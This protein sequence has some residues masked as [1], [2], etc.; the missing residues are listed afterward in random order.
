MTFPI[1]GLASV[2]VLSYNRPA[3]VREAIS[4][5]KVNAGYPCEIVVHDDGSKDPAVY[6]LLVGLVNTEQISRLILNPT[7]HNQGVGESIRAAFGVA[8]GDVVVKVD[9]DMIMSPGWLAKTVA[10]LD[11][12]VHDPVNGSQRVGMVGS[13]FTYADLRDERFRTIRQYDGFKTVTDCVSSAFAIRRDVYEE[14][15]GISTHSDAFAEDVELKDRLR[16]AGYLVVI[17][18]ADL[19]HNRGFGLP[20][21]TV[22]DGQNDDG[23][24]HVHEIHHGPVRF[25]EASVVDSDA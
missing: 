9:Q 2:C 8:S 1:Q 25:N 6:E 4:S 13:L 20:F 22:V 16:A 10:I 5:A 7:G 18:D 14:V 12:V 3:F 21:S 24:Y 19:A 17:P 11:A 15:G 23:S